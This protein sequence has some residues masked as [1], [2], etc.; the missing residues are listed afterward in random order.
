MTTNDISFIN[1]LEDIT[2]E[3][4]PYVIPRAIAVSLWNFQQGEEKQ[5][6]QAMLVVKIP[7]RPDA[8]FPMNF[9]SG[10]HRCRAIQGVLEIPVDAPCDATFEVRLNGKHAASHTVKIHPP[11]VRAATEGGE[12]MPGAKA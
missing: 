11:E 4:F 1:V 12:K 7:E 10:V 6:Y 3:A 5:D 8:A 9:S 2:P